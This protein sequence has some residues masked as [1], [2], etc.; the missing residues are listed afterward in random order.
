MH[1]TSI[2]RS[3]TSRAGAERAVL[4]GALADILAASGVLL[5]L[6]VATA[7]QALSGIARFVASRHGLSEAAVRAGL[8]EREH[9]GS[10][11]L[12]CGVAIPHARIKGLLRPIAAY[13][14][15]A[16]PVPF[17]AP[18]GKPVT[19]MLVLLVPW[20][21]TEEHLVM[22]A[23]AAAMFS[24]TAFRE[25]LRSCADRDSVYALLVRRRA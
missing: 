25:E 14:R 21:S 9:I 18:D 12:G 22:L 8:A 24:D 19:D 15:T 13:V 17:D 1:P 3:S 23:E 2:D 20:E 6:D 11:G 7:G 4:S 10:T 16:L 5:G